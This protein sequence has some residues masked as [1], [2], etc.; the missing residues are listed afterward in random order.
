MTA[1]S[2]NA[3]L[4]LSDDNRDSRMRYAE[5]IRTSAGHMASML[6][7]LL[8]YFRLD[9]RKV[10]ILSKPFKLNLIADTL[11]TEFAAQVQS[12]HLTL[13]VRNHANEV[14]NGDKNRILSIGGNLLSN[15]IKFTDSGII[16]LTT[17]YKD[18]VFTLA[19]EDTGTGISEGQ[20]ERIFKPFERLGNAATQ[21]GFGL[22]LSIVKQLVELMDGSISVESEKDKGSKFTVV[23]PLPKTEE[24]VAEVKKEHVQDIISNYSVIVIDN[25][26]V[27]L[28]MIRD[29]LVQNGIGCDTCLMVEELTDKMRGKDYDLLIT[30]LKMP[31]MNGYEVLELLRASDVGNSHTI[32]VVAAT[33]AGFIMEEELKSVGFTAM[34]GKPFSI[35]ELLN[36]VSQYANKEHRQQPDFSALLT[37]GDKRHTLEQLVTETKKEIEEVRKAAEAKDRDALD[38]WIHHL[39]SSWML[40]KVE[41]PLQELY[42]AI[43][44]NNPTDGEIAHAVQK[45]LTQGKLIVDLA[46]KEAERWEE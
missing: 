17:Q 44:S 19:V 33:A 12:K 10:A 2:G 6:N 23:L 30:D 22:G 1:I 37:F 28:G 3:E 34:L 41:Q 4:L 7:S 31:D 14:V 24:A 46:R 9:S 27:T 26:L 21:D 45:V 13:T 15:A 42:A 25:D 8:E 39:R 11:E 35:A 20:K 29:M 32:P 16:T 5:V 18:G 43:H 38:G 36:V 40:M